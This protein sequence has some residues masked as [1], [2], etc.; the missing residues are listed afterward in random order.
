MPETGGMT[1]RLEQR[2]MAQEIGFLVGK[3]IFDTVAHP[4][5]CREMDDPL[6]PI[7]L[8]QRLDV[9]GIGHVHLHE[10]KIVERVQAG[11]S[12]SLERRII[13]IIEIVDADDGF[14]AISQPPR[15][16]MAD[17]AGG[18]SHQYRILARFIHIFSPSLA[19]FA[20]DLA[21]TGKDS[22][23]RKRHLAGRQ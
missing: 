14:P 3:G 2:Q 19:R 22:E 17:K 1:A 21:R 11:E 4:G 16:G 5:L 8:H 20:A 23:R 13:I 15:N 12:G 18:T 7:L 9:I 10:A 6:D